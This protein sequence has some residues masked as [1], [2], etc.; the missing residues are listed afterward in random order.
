[1]AAMWNP[2]QNQN[3]QN[4]N[5]VCMGVNCG[6]LASDFYFYIGENHGLALSLL[7]KLQTKHS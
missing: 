5:F 1:M 6:L 4:S 7:F 2:Q 3:I